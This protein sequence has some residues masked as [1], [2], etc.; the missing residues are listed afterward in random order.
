MR[1]LLLLFMDSGRVDRLTFVVRTSG[2][3]LPRFA[4]PTSLRSL[5]RSRS[6]DRPRHR[7]LT[8]LPQH[9]GEIL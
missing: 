5:G 4:E 6:P 1:Q 2:V 3:D 9:Y 7:D 8:N